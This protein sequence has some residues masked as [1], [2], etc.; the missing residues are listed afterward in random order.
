MVQHL[1]LNKSV[2]QLCNICSSPSMRNLL[3]LPKQNLLNA[4]LFSI[5]NTCSLNSSTEVELPLLRHPQ[6]LHH[7]PLAIR[8]TPSHAQF[9]NMMQPQDCKKEASFVVSNLNFLGNQ[10]DWHG[11]YVSR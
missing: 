10:K 5:P 6:R 1:R 7:L 8:L 4:Q 11:T 3:T 9:A 2:P